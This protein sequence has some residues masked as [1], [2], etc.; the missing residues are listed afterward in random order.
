MIEFSLPGERER[1]KAIDLF[2]G[3]DYELIPKLKYI[4][5]IALRHKSYSDIEKTIYQLRRLNVHKFSESIK[6]LL[7]N[8]VHDLN[9][10]ECKK[11]AINLAK[12]GNLSNRS[13]ADLTGVSR[14]TIT[15]YL[16]IE[17]NT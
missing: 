9:K 5:E 12:N 17:T 10:S 11:I 16:K 13:I 3:F 8:V 6:E 14:D 4:L 7:K 15:K 2:S 1:S